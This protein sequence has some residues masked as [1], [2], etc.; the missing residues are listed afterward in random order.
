MRTEGRGVVLREDLI[1]GPIR[2]EVQK[3]VEVTY[4]V[5][6]RAYGEV[7][8]GVGHKVPHQPLPL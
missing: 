4:A 3:V 7:L 5:S 8:G 2:V 1:L 6:E